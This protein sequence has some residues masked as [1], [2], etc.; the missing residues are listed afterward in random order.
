MANIAQMVNVLQ[1]MILTDKEKLLLTPT[2]HVFH[3]YVPFQDATFIPVALDAG[4]W[5]QETIVLPRV[6]A[7]AAKDAQGS[8][9][10]GVDQ[11][12]S[13][14]ARRRSRHSVSGLTARYRDRRDAHGAGHR[15]RQ[16]VR[17]AEHRVAEAHHGARS[18]GDRLSV[19]LAPRSVT[20][21]AVRP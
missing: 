3:M 19:T 1:A 20:V 9:A 11:C 7:I 6:D 16:H 21:L 14:P 5:T 10:A 13:E 17:G 12:R 8:S 2:Y 15:Q 4:T 18:Q